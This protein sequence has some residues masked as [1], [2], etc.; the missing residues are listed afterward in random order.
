MS[1]SKF[2]EAWADLEGAEVLVC[3]ETEAGKRWSLDLSEAVR[4]GLH[5]TGNG[6]SEDE[7]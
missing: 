3:E 7:I 5:E 6:S 2:Y 1:R 4:L